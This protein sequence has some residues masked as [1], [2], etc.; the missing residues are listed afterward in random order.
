MII[1]CQ[2]PAL[3][4]PYA[5]SYFSLLLVPMLLAFSSL[6]KFCAP[7]SL[8]FHEYSSLTCTHAN[9]TPFAHTLA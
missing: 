4:M 3:R 7:V 1:A 2:F 8:V 6:H 5:D 9:P